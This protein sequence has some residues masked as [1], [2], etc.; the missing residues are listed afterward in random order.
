[1]V[2]FIVGVN[3]HIFAGAFRASLTCWM[4]SHRDMK[5]LHW[6]YWTGRCISCR[7]K[8]A[9]SHLRAWRLAAVRCVSLFVYS[10]FLGLNTAAQC[11]R[12]HTAEHWSAAPP[13]CT[14]SCFY[15][16]FEGIYGLL[17]FTV[18]FLLCPGFQ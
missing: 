15:C 14:V 7:S 10:V 18:L 6:S 3:I 13:V 9:G 17:M 2:L 12:V 1:M 16:W 11:A 4:E 5:V 8:G